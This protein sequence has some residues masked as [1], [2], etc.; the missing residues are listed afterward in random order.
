MKILN[1][2]FSHSFIF[3][4]K[5]LIVALSIY[6]VSE[7]LVILIAPYLVDFSYE[8][9]SNTIRV[10]LPAA[11]VIFVLSALW[12]LAVITKAALRRYR[13]LNLF[14]VILNLVLAAGYLILYYAA[15]VDDAFIE[16]YQVLWFAYY[17]ALAM[18]GLVVVYCLHDMKVKTEINE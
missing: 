17:P 9:P 13:K 2:N 1:L 11:E 7:L 6:I 5:V 4:C 3:I 10:A 16:R 15:P 14:A 12:F 8:Y 18:I